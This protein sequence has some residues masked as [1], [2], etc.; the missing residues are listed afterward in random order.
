MK[1]ETF[2]L[3]LIADMTGVLEDTV[4]LEDAE[5]Y[6]T[7][8]GQMMGERIYQERG[9]GPDQPLPEADLGD[10]LV[11]LKSKIEGGFSVDEVRANGLTFVNDKCP[12]GARVEGR[13]SLCMMTSNVF[14]FLASQCKGYAK[15]ELERTI[16]LG[17]SMCRVHVH[18][19]K[20]DAAGREYYKIDRSDD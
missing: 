15:V 10:V 19:D 9:F 5:G 3:D 17:D 1:R 18:F 13:R 8:V 20:N 14:G 12:F 2:C 7:I 11:D 6:V 16:A 4:G